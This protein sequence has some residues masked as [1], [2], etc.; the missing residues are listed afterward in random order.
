MLEAAKQ[1]GFTLLELIAVMLILGVAAMLIAPRVGAGW[2]RMNDREFLNSFAATMKKARVQALS[3]MSSRDFR[4]D[5]PARR[6]G[7]GGELEEDVPANVDI[8]SEGLLLEGESGRY[9]VRFFSDGSTSGGEIDVIFDKDR[10]YLV[11][12]DR[13]LGSVRVR[14]SDE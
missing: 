4:I 11:S 5:G 3:D 14:R 13:V 10:K 12:L 7:I 9:V 6:Y 1:R 2:K 8:Y